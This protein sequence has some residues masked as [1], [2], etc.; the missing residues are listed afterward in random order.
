MRTSVGWLTGRPSS[1]STCVNAVI[2]VAACHAGSVRRPSSVMGP[3]ARVAWTDGRSCRI[4][5]CAVAGVA[6][7]AASSTATL[8][9]RAQG[10]GGGIVQVNV[11]AAGGEIKPGARGNLGS[12]LNLNLVFN[13]I[14]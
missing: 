3:G 12:N 8:A 2:G 1:G 6:D 7:Q 5:C 9:G 14:R 10:G 13:A 11:G 4:A